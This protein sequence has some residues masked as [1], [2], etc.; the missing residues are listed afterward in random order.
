MNSLW[1]DKEAESAGD[2]LL[3]LRV[4][5]SRL[6]GKDPD[7]VLHGG[8]N[9]S[10]KGTATDV[11]GDTEPV[12]YVKGSG[13]DLATIEAEGFSPVKLDTLQRMAGLESLNDTAMVK[14]QR[15]AMT[16]PGAPTPSVEAILH[17]IIP[18]RFVDHTHADAVVTVTNTDR[19]EE[20]MMEIYGDRVLVIPYVMPGFILSKKVYEMTRDLDWNRIEGMIL[21]NHGIFTFSDDAQTSYENMIKLVSEAEHYLDKHAPS[22]S[23]DDAADDED[24]LELATWRKEVSRIRGSAVLAK[25]DRGPRAVT[26]SRLGAIDRV[27]RR[28]PL[29]PDHIIR[30]KLAPIIASGSPADALEQYAADYGKYFERNKVNGL[31]C[32]DPAPRW[33]VWPGQGTIAFGTSVKEAT[34]VGHINEHTVKAVTQA[35][36]LGGW[37]A[38]PE[39]DLFEVE[40]WE[41]EQ[42]KLR[43]A[44]KALTHQG[45]IALVTGAASGIGKACVETLLAQGAAVAAL[46]IDSSVENLFDDSAALGIVCDVTDSTSLKNAV[47]QTVRTYGGLDIVVSNAGTFPANSKIEDMDHDTW[48]KSVGYK[49][50]Q[51]PGIAAS[52][53]SLS[54]T[55]P[56]SCNHHDCIEERFSSRP[57]RVGLLCSESRHDTAGTRGSTRIVIT[58]RS[59]QRAPSQ[60]RFRHSVM[61]G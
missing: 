24:L 25:S 58:R 48:E 12:L 37:K 28:G 36:A 7:L 13:W 50:V 1:N 59:R 56:G 43:K 40:Y 57:R 30:T 22:N 46:D 9:T 34:I 27:A 42:A 60:C 29:T 52:L 35:E 45:K 2:D 53:H 8:G 6:L 32:L 17:A 47:D 4:Y 15:A 26:F 38:L 14:A 11:F 16:E 51:S 10:V 3:A 5:T 39:T 33:C 23:M 61:D 44:G 31:S 54:F 19:G 49:S 55:G 18:F 20:R 21:M 41:L